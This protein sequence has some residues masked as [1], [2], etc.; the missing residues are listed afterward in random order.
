MNEA[1]TAMLRYCAIHSLNY[2]ILLHSNFK[3]DAIQCSTK[4]NEQIEKS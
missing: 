2:K 4:K 1:A 3:N